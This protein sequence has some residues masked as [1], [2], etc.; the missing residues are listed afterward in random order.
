MKIGHTIDSNGFL[1]GDILEDSGITPDVTVLC[2]DGFYTPKWNG[3][4]W[5]EGL[6]QA[7]IDAIINAPK[8]PSTEERLAAAESALLS[9]MGL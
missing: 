2:P 4:A 7:E 6:T 5:V 9:I 1:T 8:T 3:T